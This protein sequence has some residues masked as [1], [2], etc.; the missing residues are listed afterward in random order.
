MLFVMFGFSKTILVIDLGPV[1]FCLL[2]DVASE[3]MPEVELL[4]QRDTWLRFCWTVSN[5]LCGAC[6]VLCSTSSISQASPAELPWS[7]QTSANL[8]AETRLLCHF[9]L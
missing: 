4:G 1:S 6:A 7:F 8:M 9:S 5:S 2:G 3:S